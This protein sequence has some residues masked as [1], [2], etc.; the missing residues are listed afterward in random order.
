MMLSFKKTNHQQRFSEC[1][2][3]AF[4][5]TEHDSS[6]KEYILIFADDPESVL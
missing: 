5:T 3:T 6:F 4:S 2:E 1:S